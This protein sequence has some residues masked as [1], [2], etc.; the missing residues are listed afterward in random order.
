MSKDKHQ[1]IVYVHEYSTIFQFTYH[2]FLVFFFSM[3]T[4]LKFWSTIVKK[5]QLIKRN[6]PY[7]YAIFRKP[8][9]LVTRLKKNFRDIYTR[10]LFCKDAVF[11]LEKV[12]LSVVLDECT[13]K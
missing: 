5:Q 6:A 3:L 4:V 7:Y 1:I 12:S 13:S 2:S 9:I 8:E 10:C 11:R